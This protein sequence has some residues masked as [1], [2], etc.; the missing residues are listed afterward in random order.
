L[1]FG[2]W[3]HNF[4]IKPLKNRLWEISGFWCHTRSKKISFW[5]LVYFLSSFGCLALSQQL[6]QQYEAWSKEARRKKPTS[7]LKD[8]SVTP[9]H[10]V[11]Q[12]DRTEPPPETAFLKWS[13]ATISLGTP[14]TLLQDS[15]TTS[16]AREDLCPVEVESDDAWRIRGQFC[17]IVY[18]G[19]VQGGSRKVYNMSTNEYAGILNVII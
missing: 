3:C 12:V 2:F 15:T 8:L 1:I 7:C 10:P 13:T 5:L 9:H 17:D 16:V 4:V 18:P 19:G 11:D 14:G 6:K